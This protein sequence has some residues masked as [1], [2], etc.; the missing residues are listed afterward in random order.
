MGAK[1]K[2]QRKT[3]EPFSKHYPWGPFL[4]KNICKFFAFFIFRFC[5]S[6]TLQ[7]FSRTIMNHFLTEL[8][9]DSLPPP[10]LSLLWES[11]EPQINA[12]LL[13][14]LLVWLSTWNSCLKPSF[15]S[16]V[17]IYSISPLMGHHMS[18][19]LR[20]LATVKYNCPSPWLLCPSFQVSSVLS[21]ISYI[22]LQHH[23]QGIFPSRWGC[24]QLFQ[25]YSNRQNLCFIQ[26]D[27]FMR[28]GWCLKQAKSFEKW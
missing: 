18:L 11:A 4:E 16:S 17:H 27:S 14:R 22:F 9:P 10:V 13:D 1:K 3:R 7:R 26:I 23:Y 5:K 19:L 12:C 15:V 8:T 21:H 24:F 28:K 2:K 20:I 6:R 25:R